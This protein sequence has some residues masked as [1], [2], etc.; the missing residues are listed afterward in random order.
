M[1]ANV[2]AT[3]INRYRA[4]AAEKRIYGGATVTE[5][6]CGVD[7]AAPSTWRKIVGFGKTPSERKTFAIK[8]FLASVV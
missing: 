8:A 2:F 6:L 4:T 5:F 7:G 1:T 3:S